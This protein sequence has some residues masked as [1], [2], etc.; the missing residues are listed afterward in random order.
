MEKTPHNFGLMNNQLSQLLQ[1]SKVIHCL[2]VFGAT[3]PSGPGPP[4]SLN[5]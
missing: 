3:A 4:Y 2:F 1:F 5:L